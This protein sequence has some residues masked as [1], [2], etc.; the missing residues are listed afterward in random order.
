MEW[1]EKGCYKTPICCCEDNYF[2]KCFNYHWETYDK[3]HIGKIGLYSPFTSIA[4]FFT[5]AHTPIPVLFSFYS[6]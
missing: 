5:S 2:C 4:G 6:F 1:E 3:F